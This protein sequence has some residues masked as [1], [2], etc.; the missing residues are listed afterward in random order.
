MAWNL[1]YDHLC[2][3]I[4]KD[5]GRLARFNAQTPMTFARRGLPVVIT[6]DDFLEFK[7]SEVLQIAKSAPQII[8]ANQHKILK[9]KLDRRNIAAHPSGI[10]IMPQTAEEYIREL[11][12]VIVLQLN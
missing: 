8:N 1:A 12:E 9:E 11:I 6:R 5:P 10:Q 2:Q 3:W 4:L 7:E